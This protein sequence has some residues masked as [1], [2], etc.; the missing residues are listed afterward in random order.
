MKNS[1]YLLVDYGNTNI[2]C[3]IYDTKSKKLSG[4]S[5]INKRTNPEVLFK[6]LR[7]TK[8]SNLP[9]TFIVSTVNKTML[10]SFLN[11]LTS[12]IKT[13]VKVINKDDFADLLDFSNV[14]KKVVIGNDLLLLGLYVANN[15]GNGCVICLGT[16]YSSVIMNGKRFESVLLMPNISDSIQNIPNVSSIPESLL[17]KTYNKT[18]GL[19]TPDCFASGANIMLEGLAINIANTYEIDKRDIVITGGDANKYSNLNKEYKV[20]NH[21]TIKSLALLIQLKKW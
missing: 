5:I 19:N 8:K 13:E 2:K 17:P 7:I 20:I 4:I 21:L 16:V 11:H 12:I 15:Y 1:K 18:I 6:K 14:S 9:K 3:G 10:E